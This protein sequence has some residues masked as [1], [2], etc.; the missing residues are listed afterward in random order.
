MDMQPGVK[1]LNVSGDTSRRWKLTNYATSKANLIPGSPTDIE[2]YGTE[3]TNPNRQ[4]YWYV[5]FDGNDMGKDITVNYD[6][7]IKYYTRLVDRAT[8]NL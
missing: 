2:W 8:V 6:V 4:W 7:Y 1:R 5:Y 3:S